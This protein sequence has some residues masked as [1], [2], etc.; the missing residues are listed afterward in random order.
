M[1]PKY[2]FPLLAFGLFF[3]MGLFF[4]FNPSYEKSIRAKYYFEIG[5]YQE[6]LALA[7]E[8]F[9]EDLYNRMAATVMAQSITSLKY[10]AY[11]EDAKKYMVEIDAIAKH[12]Y[13]S[14]VDKA[15]I[16]VICSIMQ[17]SYIKLAPSVVTQKDLVEQAALYHKQFEQ[18]FAKVSQ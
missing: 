18:L 15:K 8:A 11:I 14:D 16:R 10:I 17:S 3:L 7:K 12:E 2:L 6:A 4:L 5:E 9:S 1:Q 13:I